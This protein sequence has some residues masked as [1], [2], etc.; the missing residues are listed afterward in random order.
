VVT[1][2]RHERVWVVLLFIF[3][4]SVRIR[5]REGK[6]LGVSGVCEVVKDDIKLVV[7]SC[8]WRRSC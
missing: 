8:K 1:C 3:V 4:L 5:K 6:G 7:F 2:G